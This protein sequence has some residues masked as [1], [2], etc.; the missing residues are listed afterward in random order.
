MTAKL[1]EGFTTGSAATG[2]ALA[3]LHL[4]M[5]G[6]APS[7]VD[8]PLPPF[9]FPP[10]PSP[11]PNSDGHLAATDGT[12]ASTVVGNGFAGEGIPIPR[13][14]L[15]LEVA[16]CDHG[17]APELASCPEFAALFTQKTPSAQTAHSANASICPSGQNS[18]QGSLGVAH[19]SIRKDGGDD[20]DATSGAL[21]TVTVVENFPVAEQPAISHTIEEAD[22]APGLALPFTVS[23]EG[24]PGV[25]RVTLPG[26]PVPVGEAAV[27]PTP[28]QQITLA[29][30][31]AA[32]QLGERPGLSLRVIISVPEGERLA[33]QTFNPRLGIVGGISILGTQGTVRPYSHQAWKATIEQGLAVALAT[34]CRDMGLTTGRRS[35]RLLMDKYPQMP[36]RSFIQVAD[37]AAFS[38]KAAGAMPFENLIWGCFFGKLVKLAQGHAYTHARHADLDMEDL[39]RLCRQCSAACADEVRNCV[40]AAHALELLLQDK[41]GN[42]VIALTGEKAAAVAANFAGRHVRLHLFHT[43]GR[44][45][46]AL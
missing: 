31:C 5:T 22:D 35:E 37:F 44:E 2:A 23:I 46:L 24:G 17:P 11:A 25:G 39:A 14:M 33:R 13:G 36:Q 12:A 8:V 26:L 27:N 4:L 21:I 40:T 19:A 41:A 28:R 30:R 16:A 45:L 6:R 18:T 29:L 3:A 43:D 42:D 10:V 32:L 15:R 1:R 34:G 20:P 9:S 38:L 7:H